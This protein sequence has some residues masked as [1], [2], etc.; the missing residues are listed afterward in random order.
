MEITGP[1]EILTFGKVAS[2]YLWT[3]QKR[4]LW[5]TLCYM[6]QVTEGI[7]PQRKWVKKSF[8]P[9]N[10]KKKNALIK[11]ISPIV[12]VL[13]LGSELNWFKLSNL[14]QKTPKDTNTLR[15]WASPPNTHGAVQGRRHP[16]T[17]PLVRSWEGGMWRKPSEKTLQMKRKQ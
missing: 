9:L 16:K 6:Q 1:G 5:T 14:G 15:L 10:K 11:Y 8:L 2:G 4:W 3:A 17:E 7:R 13:D 12:I